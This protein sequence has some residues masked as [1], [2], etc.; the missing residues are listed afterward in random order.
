MAA[1][2]SVSAK[3]VIIIDGHVLLTR[4]QGGTWE[5]PG[6]KLAA[7][8][9][10]KDALVRELD[11]ELGIDVE[12]GDIL[13]CAVRRKRRKRD[14][15]MVAYLCQTSTP[16]DHMRLSDEHIE[17]RLFRPSKIAKRRMDKV[18]KKAIELGFTRVR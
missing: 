14:V 17:A 6:G 1:K 8:E 9:T 13:H 16:V 2:F 15:F 18:Y 4:T 12:I 10:P 11:E 5:L 3:A 7:G